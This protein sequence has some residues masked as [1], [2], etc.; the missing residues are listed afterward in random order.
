MYLQWGTIR[1]SYNYDFAQRLF[2]DLRLETVL[3]MTL[4]KDIYMIGFI[5]LFN[6]FLVWLIKQMNNNF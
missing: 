3:T 1:N 5:V 2:Y 6:K 4:Q